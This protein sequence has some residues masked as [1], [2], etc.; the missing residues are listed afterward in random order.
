MKTPH[1]LRARKDPRANR[2]LVNCRLPAWMVDWINSQDKPKTEVIETAIKD[3]YGLDGFYY[4]DPK[5]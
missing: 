4:I 1:N 3:R 2:Q 5:K